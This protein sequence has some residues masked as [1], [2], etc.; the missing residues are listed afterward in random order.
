MVHL[1]LRLT[2]LD[3]QATVDLLPAAHVSIALPESLLPPQRFNCSRVSRQGNLR[4][5]PDTLTSGH[6]SL[7]HT[8][9]HGAPG[10]VLAPLTLW[11]LKSFSHC[12]AVTTSCAYRESLNPNPLNQQQWSPS[13]RIPAGLWAAPPGGHK[14]FTMFNSNPITSL[15]VQTK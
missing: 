15:T 5:R 11:S 8:G 1:N 3:T 4:Q 6:T 14:D 2:C 9:P 13:P 10:P 7:L 12:W